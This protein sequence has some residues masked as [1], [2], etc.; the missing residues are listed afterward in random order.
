MIKVELKTKDSD[1]ISVG[2]N[3]ELYL[4]GVRAKGVKSFKYEVN[5]RGVGIVTLEYYANVTINSNVPNIIANA[6][7]TEE[8]LYQEFGNY[9]Q[10][11]TGEDNE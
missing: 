10:S 2:A 8:T 5:A 7:N 3:T 11:Y 9:E 4:D 1:K 6:V